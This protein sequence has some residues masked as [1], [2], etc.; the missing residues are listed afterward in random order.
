MAHIGAFGWTLDLALGDGFLVSI[1]N[2]IHQQCVFIQ[3]I[4]FYPQSKR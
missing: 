4:Y 2:D 3:D 1:N